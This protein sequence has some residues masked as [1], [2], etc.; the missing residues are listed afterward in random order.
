MEN[1]AWQAV[2]ANATASIVLPIPGGP[3]RATL[4]L[5]LTNSKVARSLIL[6]A[7][8]PCWKAQS[9]WS[10][11]FVVRQPGQFQRVAE[12]APFAQPDFFL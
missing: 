8:R 6:R 7:S 9:N 12:R 5:A 4:D 10:N 11:V 3:S 1:P 2:T